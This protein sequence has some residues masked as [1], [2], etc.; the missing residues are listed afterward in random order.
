MSR[1][2]DVAQQHLMAAI[3]RD[4]PGTDLPRLAKVLDALIA[5]SVARPD[6][7]AFRTDEGRTEVL[8][9]GL[10]GTKVV[11][12]SATVTRGAGPKLE[13]Y[14]PTGRALSPAERAH[15]METLNAHSREVLVDGD[16]LRI[17]FGALKNDAARAAVLG[18]MEELLAASA[19]STGAAPSPGAPPSGP[20][21]ASP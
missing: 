1:T 13:I 12:W 14:P 18:L 3:Q 16:R 10:T 17:G 9:F 8:S 11:F 7:L 2:L 5:W 15:V 19:Q 4:T 21:A 20:K 6:Q